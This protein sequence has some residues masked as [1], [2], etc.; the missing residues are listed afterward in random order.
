MLVEDFPQLLFLRKL[1]LELGERVELL[2]KTV[3]GLMLTLLLASMLFI[4]LDMR[5]V[6][7]VFSQ[8]EFITILYPNGGEI[9]TQGEQ[10]TILWTSSG[11]P[12]YAG[13]NLLQNDNAVLGIGN[14]PNTGSYVWTVPTTFSGTGFTIKIYGEGVWDYSDAPFSI[15]PAY[16]QLIPDI[17]AGLSYDPL[18]N[19]SLLWN[20]TRLFYHNASDLF[21]NE[22][23]WN[24]QPIINIQGIVYDPTLNSF[25][26]LIW[27]SSRL[28][29]HYAD[30]SFVSEVTWNGQS[31]TDVQGIVYDPEDIDP[32]TPRWSDSLIWTP[33]R[34]FHHYASNLYVDEVT[35]RQEPIFSYDPAQES[36]VQVV[37]HHIDLCAAGIVGVPAL[38]P[39]KYTG[40]SNAATIVES[41]T[42]PSS[43]T[44]ILGA[45]H[46][47]KTA[48]ILGPTPVSGVLTMN[49]MKLFA[50]RAHK[51]GVKNMV[52]FNCINV[53][54]DTWNL[55]MYWGN[56]CF[57][58]QQNFFLECGNGTI[59]WIQNVY[60]AYWTGTP[61]I[62]CTL[63]VTQSAWIFTAD[64]GQNSIQVANVSFA[65]PAWSLTEAGMTPYV[66]LELN[67]YIN[68]SRL[69]MS[70]LQAGAGSEV[71]DVGIGAR[72]IEEPA[73]ANVRRVPNWPNANTRPQLVLV[74]YGESSEAIW[75][76]CTSGWVE[77][78]EAYSLVG[79]VPQWVQDN[80][81]DVVTNDNDQTGETS[82]NLDWEWTPGQRRGAFRYDPCS[83]ETGIASYAFGALGVNDVAVTNITTS[84]TVVGQGFNASI[85]VTMT[86]Q[87]SYTETFNVTVYANTTSIA[88]QTITL[89][90][91]NSTTITF[92]WNTTG[93]A[94]GN[95][96]ISAYA[97]PVKGETDTADNRKENG[98]IVVSIYC[99]VNGDGIVDISDIL[100]T[101]LAFGAT[102]G[103]P[104]WNP[105]CDIDDNGIIDISD[106]L[107]VALHYGQT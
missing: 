55:G 73:D 25:S 107:E 50:L 101:A 3:S 18:G 14:V 54:D 100:D 21:V 19:S 71:A 27:N 41:S 75:G 74:G 10:V 51:I 88:T 48:L 62:N 66:D 99:D 67:S 31:V 104:R 95:Y 82:H 7:T 84:K 65:V 39:V 96:T 64:P 15:V 85:N 8:E 91:G 69:M 72:I 2:R 42:A 63:Y 90:S 36:I 5:V 80:A 86:N 79:G 70:G 22:T 44:T 76:N 38:T 26:S 49:S 61:C 4:I 60:H 13:L 33:R 11:R 34:V 102:P 92:T 29:Y 94:K 81:A 30:Y 58:I 35:W 87:G 59:R 23:T 20:S 40:T 78:Y 32:Y 77:D 43:H 37:I 97:W 83:N 12:D 1:Y 56:R 9:L 89:T 16:M 52:H 106:I 47:Y 28:F 6:V 45:S 53:T 57:T 98:W 46:S 24:G 105:N 17:T 68:G 103:Q 93:F